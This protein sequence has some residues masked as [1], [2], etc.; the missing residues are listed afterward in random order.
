MSSITGPFPID[1]QSQRG[2]E[3]KNSTASAIGTSS[4]GAGSAVAPSPDS[5]TDGTQ[6]SQLA[7]LLSALRVLQKTDPTEFR[8]VIS[9]L[10]ASLSN[11]AQG[12]SS[13]GNAA[14]ASV[15]A[16]L[17]SDVTD[18][19]EPNGTAAIPASKS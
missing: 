19:S 17:E 6:L 5:A 14:A 10:S 18:A 12:A 4:T 13:G 8:A 1:L 9:D 3:G 15:L 11:A 16:E 2:P 7:E